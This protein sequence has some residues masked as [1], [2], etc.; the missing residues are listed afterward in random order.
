MMKLIDDVG[1]DSSFSFVFSPRPGTPAANLHDDTPHEVKLERLQHLQA[2]IEAN[3]RRISASARRH[4]AA[5]PGR[6]PVA[7]G[8]Q[9]ADG[10]HRVQPH[11]Q[12]RRRPARAAGRP[13][14]RRA[15]HRRRCRTRCAPRC[16]CAKALEPER[17][18]GASAA[19]AAQPAHHRPSEPSRQHH[20][21]RWPSCRRARTPP[22]PPA[23]PTRTGCAGPARQP[24][25]AAPRS[26]R[27]HSSLAS[28]VVASPTASAGREEVQQVPQRRPG[29]HASES[30]ESGKIGVVLDG[31][32][33][34]KRQLGRS[35]CR[36]RPNFIIRSMSVFA[37]G[38]NHTT[39]PL[40]LR[41]RFA[42]APEQ[43]RAH[44]ARLSRAAG[45]AR[46]RGGDPLHLQPHRAVRAAPS[47]TLVHAGR[48]LAGRHRRREQPAAARTTPTCSK[49]AP[50]RGMPSASPAGS[51]RWCWASRRSSAR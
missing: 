42:F 27:R 51:T 16:C 22:A 23:K 25:Q 18:L 15:H 34:T 39:A 45:A 10:P 48:R 12:L 37:L 35:P 17:G 26:S 46:G 4:G 5:H 6:R 44:P 28:A 11:R 41:G 3:V 40:D 47:P 21:H 20:G 32:K 50:P 24:P 9:R 1:F 8:R 19:R 30:T 14:D 49:T 2:A 38:L 13:D 29:A 43:T 31:I 33:L 36:R 7:Q